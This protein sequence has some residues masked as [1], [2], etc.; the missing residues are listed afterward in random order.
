M[1]EFREDEASQTVKHNEKG[2]L[3]EQMDKELSSE[4]LLHQRGRFELDLSKITRLSR[5]EIVQACNL[6]PM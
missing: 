4:R 3:R 2:S 1:V 6:I 5:L